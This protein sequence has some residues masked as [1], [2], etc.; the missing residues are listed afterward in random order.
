MTVCPTWHQ[1]SGVGGAAGGIAVG[2][3]IAV[4]TKV[5]AKSDFISLS[6]LADTRNSAIT[7]KNAS[8]HGYVSLFSPF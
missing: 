5:V 7:A 1:L 8:P 3:A 2:T 6:Q 4:A